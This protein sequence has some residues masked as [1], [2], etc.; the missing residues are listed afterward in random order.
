MR[1]RAFLAAAA[2]AGAVTLAGCSTASGEVSPPSLP[3]DRLD[4]LGYV[5]IDQEQE[6]V[7][8]EEY[9][10][11]ELTASAHTLVYEDR[12]LTEDVAERTLGLVE[13]P[14][15]TFF[16]TRVGFSPEIDDLPGG[17]GRSQILEEVEKSSKDSFRVQMESYGIENIEEVGEGTLETDSGVDADL[18][19]F[20]GV[21][22]FDGFAFPVTDDHAVEI[23]A[24]NVSVDGWLAVWFDG[25]DTLV[26]GGVH[27]A[28][29]FE[30]NVS[31]SLSSGIDV[32]ID[33]DMGMEPDRYREEIHSLMKA[34]T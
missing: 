9:A 4:E 18:T 2:G 34:V 13:G 31:E 19:E 30:E 16:A 15:A 3:N 10:G 27:P 29:S 11:I 21:F 8:E 5:E 26:A 7:F 17:V 22:P 32:E 33:V 24:D 12:E 1:R 20:T 14:L 28:E 25:D 23:D 6:T